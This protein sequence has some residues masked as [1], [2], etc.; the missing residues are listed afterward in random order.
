M[1]TLAYGLLNILTLAP[2]SGYDL[3]LR[4]Q[5]FWPAKHSQIYPILASLEKEGLVSCEW[6]QQSDKPDKKVYSITE[7]GFE[8]LRAWK[9]EPLGD[10]VLRDEMLLKLYGLPLDELGS[11]RKMIGERLEFYRLKIMQVEKKLEKFRESEEGEPKPGSTL[12][13]VYLLLRKAAFDLQAGISWCE[14]ALTQ[15]QDK[16]E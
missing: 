4:I 1:N 7:Q 10:P 3:M 13:G 9:C 2:Q 15:L 16:N 11:Y 5:S 14:W 12:L 6:V 8:S